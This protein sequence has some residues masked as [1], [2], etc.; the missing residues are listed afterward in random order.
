MYYLHFADEKTEVQKGLPKVIPEN[1]VQ[2]S[3]FS[4]TFSISLLW[5]TLL[6]DYDKDGKIS[7]ADF[8]KAVREERLLLEVFGPCLPETKKCL[9][10]EAVAFRNI[11]TSCF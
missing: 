10:F 2:N 5:T 9:D 6:K 4:E 3:S 7:F 1:G 11:L 8:E